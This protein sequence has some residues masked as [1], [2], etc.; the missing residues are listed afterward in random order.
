MEWAQLIV[1]LVTSLFAAAVAIIVWVL[2]RRIDRRNERD[3][4]AALYVNPFILACHELQ[5][6]LYNILERGGIEVIKGRDKQDVTFQKPPLYGDFEKETLYLIAQYFAWEHHVYR[7]GPYTRD[8]DV[9]R[10]TEAVRD[11]FATNKLQ[12]GALCFFRP[13]Q[14]TMGQL[15]M[16]RLESPLGVEFEVVPIHEFKK[17]LDAPPLSEMPSALATLEALREARCDEELEGCDRLARVQNHL[18][19]LLSYLEAREGFTLFPGQRNKAEEA[20]HAEHSR[21]RQPQ[22]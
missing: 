2:Q 19:E 6:R 10:L 1:A 15:V 9:M 3:R 21:K 7:Y 22:V 13:D 17:M 18:V 11:S 14:R 5:S 12:V 4:I 20:K 8:Q 16:K